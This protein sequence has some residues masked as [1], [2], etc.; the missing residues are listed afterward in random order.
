MVNYYPSVGGGRVM[1]LRPSQYSVVSLDLLNRSF[2]GHL[3][4]ALFM[5]RVFKSI[6]ILDLDCHY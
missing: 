6:V 5:D 3:A 4:R 1:D 2:C